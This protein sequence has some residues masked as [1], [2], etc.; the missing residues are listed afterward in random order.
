MEGSPELAQAMEQLGVKV[1][2]NASGAPKGLSPVGVSVATKMEGKA[3]EM[4]EGAQRSEER[5]GLVG[6]L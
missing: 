6:A 1:P 5:F 4:F 2:T 3:I